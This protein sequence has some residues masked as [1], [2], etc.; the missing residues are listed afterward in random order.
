[1]IINF[2]TFLKLM[3]KELTIEESESKSKD[4]Y[5][6]S[7]VSD[8]TIEEILDPIEEEYDHDETSKK[9]YYEEYGN[10]EEDSLSVDEISTLLD[11]EYQ[12]YVER[13]VKFFFQCIKKIRSRMFA[14]KHLRNKKM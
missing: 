13:V 1:M 8:P 3:D 4:A 11:M 7:G 10:E 6:L 14:M 12:K 5:E 2:L 9:L